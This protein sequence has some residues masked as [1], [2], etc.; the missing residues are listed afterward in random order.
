MA[1][2]KLS[3]Q[4]ELGV[5][6]KGADILVS[7]AAG[8]GKTFV[9]VERIL[10]R[11]MDEEHPC[12]IDQF[13]LVT[14]TKAAAAEMRLRIAARIRSALAQKGEDRHLQRQLTLLHKASINT[15]HSFCADLIRSNFHLLGVPH[16]FRI[17]EEAEADL[18]KD[19]VLQEVVEDAFAKYTYDEVSFGRLVEL[20]AE[21]RSDDGA[22]R[23]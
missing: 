15:V 13:L 4:Q 8:S 9:L 11:I 16:N 22:V 3:P 17:C 2:V 23:C 5:H 14:Y 19:E 12:D 20:L 6:L 1:E 7:A 10:N 21:D 18:L